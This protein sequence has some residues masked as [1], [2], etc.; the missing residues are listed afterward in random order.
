MPPSLSSK[1]PE[2]KKRVWH[3]VLGL[4]FQNY[5]KNLKE[6]LFVKCSDGNIRN[7]AIVLSTYL[8]D[9]PEIETLNGLVQVWTVSD[10]V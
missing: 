1:D 10:F 8:G 5:Q 7:I 6:D 3:T 4:I 9:H 2:E